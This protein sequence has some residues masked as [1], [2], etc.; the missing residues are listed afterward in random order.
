MNKL[1]LLIII[2]CFSCQ[3]G[4]LSVIADL[5][6]SLKETSAVELIGN[7]NLIWVIE[8]AGNKNILY[9]LNT[10]G[11]IVKEI[12]ITNAKNTDWEDL[13]SDSL[14]NIYIGDFGNNSKKPEFF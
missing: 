4:N 6:N 9:G 13:A 7:S 10:K 14:G 3:T 2:L 8:D 1:P 12:K 5:P 11:K